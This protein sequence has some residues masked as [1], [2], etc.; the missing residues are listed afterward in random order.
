MVAII[1]RIYR[2]PNG[3]SNWNPYISYISYKYVHDEQSKTYDQNNGPEKKLSEMQ[4]KL[5]ET[6]KQKK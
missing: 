6:E 3:T 2:K 4:Y 5:Y 1:D